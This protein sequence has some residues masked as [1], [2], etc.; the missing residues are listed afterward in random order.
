M[1]LKD[2]LAALA[3]TGLAAAQSAGLVIPADQPICRIYTVIQVLGTAGGI[4]AA[5]YGGFKIASS[6]ELTERNNAKMLIEGVLI[7]LIIIYAA[8]FVVKYIVGSSS[9]CGW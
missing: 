1:K 2:T 5:G 9:M 7:G 3:L 8:P 6:H 4:L